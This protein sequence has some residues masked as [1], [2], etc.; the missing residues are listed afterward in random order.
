M[1]SD[2][3]GWLM[4]S[5]RRVHT[6]TYTALRQKQ[7]GLLAVFV[8]FV[9]GVNGNAVLEVEFLLAG[10][11]IFVFDV[12]CHARDYVAGRENSTGRST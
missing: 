9:L 6:R 5:V 7:S 3:Y 1:G 2:E 12:A 10:G 8:V 11:A 4:G